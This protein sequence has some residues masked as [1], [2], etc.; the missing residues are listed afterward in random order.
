[1][2]TPW[3]VHARFLTMLDR[4]FPSRCTIKQA[5][6]TYEASGEL[7]EGPW[8]AVSAALTDLHCRVSPVSGAE[9]REPTHTFT[10]VTHTITLAGRY[11]TILPHMVAVVGSTTY[12]IEAVEGDGSGVMTRLTTRVVVK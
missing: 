10:Q 6:N 11:D 8:V 9:T 4:V 3:P 5:T 7:T 1:M 2:T 12:E